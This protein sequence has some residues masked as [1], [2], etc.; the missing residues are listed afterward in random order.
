MAEPD[1]YEMVSNYLCGAI[2]AVDLRHWLI[3]GYQWLCDE[4]PDDQREFG[5]TAMNLG[6]IHE[7]GEWTEDAFHRELELE[8]RKAL[9]Q[10]PSP[11]S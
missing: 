10:R 8:Y 4:A 5:F 1:V 11:V 2:S 6:F 3:G 9:K 7:S